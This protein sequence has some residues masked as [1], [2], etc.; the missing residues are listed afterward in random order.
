[1]SEPFLGEIRVF[2]GN[3]APVGWALCNGA[4]VS[5]AENDALFSLIGTTYGGD[6]VST[7]GLPDLRGSSPLHQGQGPGLTSHV[8][9][10]RG[11]VEHVTL[12]TAQMPSHSHQPVYAATATGSAPASARWAAQSSAAYSDAVPN[13]QLAGDALLPAGGGQPHENMPPFLAVTYIIA[14]YGIYPSQG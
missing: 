6:G 5:I 7:F 13:A 3:F 10:E 8:I 12:T 9:G 2:A 4:L 14:T 11:G 1:M